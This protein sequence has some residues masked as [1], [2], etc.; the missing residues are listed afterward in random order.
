MKKGLLALL[1]TVALVA[2][3]FAADQGAME[4]DIKAGF[5]LMSKI[6]WGRPYDLDVDPAFTAGVDF[7]YYVMP[8]LAIGAGI[9]YIFNS[10]VKKTMFKAGWTNIYAQAK[11]VFETGND[12]FNN[13]YPLVQVGVG[14]LRLDPDDGIEKETGLYWG[15]GVGTTIKENFVFEVLYSSSK[16]NIPDGPISDVTYSTLQLKVGYKFVF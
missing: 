2:P 5:N 16:S 9:D 4:L 8:Q 3:V 1:L 7:F 6:D 12:I 14:M 15:A 13:I 10:E 11:Y